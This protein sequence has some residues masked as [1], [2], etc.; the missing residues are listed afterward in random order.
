MLT[1]YTLED[2]YLVPK[3]A[4]ADSCDL[5]NAVWIDLITP[6]PN[7]IRA[8]ELFSDLSLPNIQDTE[9]IEA[10]SHYEVYPQGL[11]INCSFLHLVNGDFT[12]T[13]IAFL[14]NNKCLISLCAREIPVLRL[15][16]ER[17]RTTRGL[18][19]NPLST[20]TTLLEGKI[21]KLADLSEEAYLTIDKISRQIFNRNNIVLEE[22]IDNL[23][24]EDDL[25]GKIRLCL[26]DGHRDLNFLLRRGHLTD[27]NINRANDM[28]EDIKTLLTHNTFLSERLDFLLNAALGFINIE[29]NKIIKIFSI[30]AVVFMPPTVI[31]SIFGMNFHFMPELSWNWGYP[32]SLLSM[33]VAGLSPYIYFKRKGWL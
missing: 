33:I 10:S 25:I 8:V 30:V 23:S 6:K 32:L 7:E 12:I 16:Q 4:S 14:F 2:N 11:Q 15:L 26:M 17:A 18:V 21:E 20:I 13:N 29:Q 19:V 24:R 9:E 5:E 31:A 27:D 28:L 3:A 1:A 22:T